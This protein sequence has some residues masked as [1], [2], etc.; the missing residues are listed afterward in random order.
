MT[1]DSGQP[2]GHP[3][4]LETT[5]DHLLRIVKKRCKRLRKP[6]YGVHTLAKPNLMQAACKKSRFSVLKALWRSNAAPY[7]GWF[8]R[9]QS[10]SSLCKRMARS[11]ELL[12]GTEPHRDDGR[13]CRICLK[14]FAVISLA[15]T[16]YT[17]GKMHIG[18]VDV[19]SPASSF[20]DEVHTGN[21]ESFGP[22][23]FD[24]YQV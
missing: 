9:M 5:E 12:P 15:H 4:G 24:C 16:L 18:L 10:S 14:H 13:N 20:L 21:G 11:V 17:F 1:T 22:D 23:I 3:V 6:A 19:I 8:C 7:N 2:S